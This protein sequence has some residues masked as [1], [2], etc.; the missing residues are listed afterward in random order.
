MLSVITTRLIAEEAHTP[1]HNIP[2]SVRDCLRSSESNALRTI[3]KQPWGDRKI[4]DLARKSIIIEQL[5][6]SLGVYTKGSRLASV[7]R[8]GVMGI[9]HAPNLMDAYAA[10][11]DGGC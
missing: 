8:A 5:L 9:C 2:L 6:G 1:S 7:P 4:V 11:N 3:V 10:Q